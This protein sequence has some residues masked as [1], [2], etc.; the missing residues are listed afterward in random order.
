MDCASRA[1]FRVL[2]SPPFSFH[3]EE[4]VYKVSSSQLAT[5]PSFLPSSSFHPSRS[6]DCRASENDVS[7]SSVLMEEKEEEEEERIGRRGSEGRGKRRP[8]FLRV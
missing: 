8:L 4:A 6:F 2:F 3:A 1:P 5:S 7:S